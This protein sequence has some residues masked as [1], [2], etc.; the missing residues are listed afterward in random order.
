MAETRLI[1][2]IATWAFCASCAFAPALARESLEQYRTESSL[3]T[4]QPTS[5][6]AVITANPIK[7]SISTSNLTSGLLVR[8][9]SLSL[10]ESVDIALQQNISLQSSLEAL[11]QAHLA[12]RIALARFGPTF[13]AA[14]FFSQSNI[15]QMLFFPEGSIGSAPMQPVT[16][17]TAYHLIFAGTQP[18]FTGGRLRG[19]LKATKA[20]EQQTRS[21]IDAEKLSLAL[22]VKELYWQSALSRARVQVATDYVH[23]KEY[24]VQRVRK[25]VDEGEAPR[26]DLLREEAELANARSVLQDTYRSFNV[27]LINLKTI[28]SINPASDVQTEDLSIQAVSALDKDQNYWLSLAEKNRPELHQA[29]AA[30]GEAKAMHA[31]A[32]S[33][34]LPQ[35]SLFG[36]GSNGTGRL[37]GR[38]GSDYGKWGGTL[39]VIGGVTLFDSFARE[40]ELKST[41]SSIRQAELKRRDAALRIVQSVLT[42]WI[43]LQTEISKVE[44]AKQRVASA[45]EDQRLFEARYLVAKGTALDYFQA[46]LKLVES[47]FQ[48]VQA[49]HDYLVA[50]ARLE[51]ASGII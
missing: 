42:A 40:N 37:P 18:L 5:A 11:R 14:N 9:G 12:T 34:Y 49:V 24:S 6:D 8:Q 3:A 4:I 21:S 47:K 20:R 25:R 39:G 28:L 17:G 27:T 48:Y 36:L 2:S 13:S 41:N 1:A 45:T 35:V 29:D 46:A 51:A 19:N 31:V 50:K 22:T 32:R 26:A 43:D 33:K 30:I 38:D 7:L 16:N 23:L 15:D 44:L 10:K